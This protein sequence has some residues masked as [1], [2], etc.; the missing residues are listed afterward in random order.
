LIEGKN[1]GEI[2]KF[3]D[4]LT[5][6]VGDDARLQETAQKWRESVKQTAGSHV[7]NIPGE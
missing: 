7:L 1:T 4:D 5:Y 6:D 3:L 2:I